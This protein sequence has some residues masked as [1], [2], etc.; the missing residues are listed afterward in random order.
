MVQYRVRLLG[1][2]AGAMVVVVAAWAGG[3]MI[4]TPP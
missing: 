4:A 2:V 1:V 3:A